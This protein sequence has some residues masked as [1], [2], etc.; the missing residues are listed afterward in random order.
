MHRVFIIILAWC[1]LPPRLEPQQSVCG[2]PV[3]LE[4]AIASADLV[5]YGTITENRP[6]RQVIRT[7]K[8]YWWTSRGIRMVARYVWK[9]EI[10][11]TVQLV[12]GPDSDTTRRIMVGEQY[13]VL[14]TMGRMIGTTSGRGRVVAV[15]TQL[16]YR[17]GD[18]VYVKPCLDIVSLPVEGLPTGGVPR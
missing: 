7:D 16:V 11:D 9:G 6:V 15:D 3:Q 17:V 12:V 10:P 1:A 2:T 13:L 4:S 18:P 5:F 14:G 8:M